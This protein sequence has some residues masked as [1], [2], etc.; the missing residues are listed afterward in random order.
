MFLHL[1]HIN[2]YSQYIQ[3]PKNQILWVRA[4]LQNVNF[5]DFGHFWGRHGSPRAHTLGKRSHAAHEP[6]Q[7]GLGPHNLIFYIK[8]G[9][10]AWRSP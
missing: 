6:F 7:I 9:S 3:G 10:A 4:S 1:Q 5:R 8:I 2:L